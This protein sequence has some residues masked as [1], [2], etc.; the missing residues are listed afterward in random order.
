MNLINYLHRYGKNM[1]K[2]IAKMSDWSLEVTANCS[3]CTGQLMVP[4]VTKEWN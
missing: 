3:S 4:N 1:V 2:L